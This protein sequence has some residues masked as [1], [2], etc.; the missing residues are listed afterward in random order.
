MNAMR[1]LSCIQNQLGNR[2]WIFFI[3]GMRSDHIYSEKKSATID[4][5]DYQTA[6]D[7]IN[8]VKDNY[9][10][11]SNAQW[12]RIKKIDIT[13]HAFVVFRMAELW[14]RKGKTKLTLI[15]GY[16]VRTAG[17]LETMKHYLHLQL[18]NGRWKLSSVKLNGQWQLQSTVSAQHTIGKYGLS[19]NDG[20]LTWMV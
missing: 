18:G 10:A 13:C 5:F 16:S 4:W 6:K 19:W 1:P 14:N 3:R 7:E 9:L 12:R 17:E 11:D 20:E 2:L 15:I 8:Q